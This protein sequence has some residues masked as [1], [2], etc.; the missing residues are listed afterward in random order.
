MRRFQIRLTLDNDPFV[1]DE[2]QEVAN[3]LSE[4]Q[5]TVV[6]HDIDEEGPV[7]DRNGNNIGM[8]SFIGER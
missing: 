5:R 7:Y 4:I 8:W 2:R 1:M 6:L 3:V